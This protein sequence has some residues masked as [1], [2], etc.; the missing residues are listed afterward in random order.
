MGP[1]LELAHAARSASPASWLLC[2]AWGVHSVDFVFA[3]ARWIPLLRTLLRDGRLALRLVRDRRTPWM[4]KLILVGAVLY[5]LSP[6][7]LLPDLIPFLGQL[8]D[9]AI[10][11]FGLELFLKNVPDWLRAEHE[12][13]LTAGAR[14]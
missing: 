6:F 3:L 11:G 9:V 10:L 2:A 14:F 8:D 1:D 13:A 12:A 7:D 5:V 4:P